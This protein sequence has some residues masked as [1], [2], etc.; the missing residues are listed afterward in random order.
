MTGNDTFQLTNQFLFGLHMPPHYSVLSYSLMDK[1]VRYLKKPNASTSKSFK[2]YAE[3]INH[4]QD[5]FIQWLSAKWEES[6]KYRRLE[7]NPNVDKYVNH[8]Y[9]FI[10]NYLKTYY[11]GTYISKVKIDFNKDEEKFDKL[12]MTLCEHLRNA[13]SKYTSA[14]I[15]NIDI[16]NFDSKISFKNGNYSTPNKVPFIKDE[17]CCDLS[18]KHS[19]E[20]N[21]CLSSLKSIMNLEKPNSLWLLPLNITK[22]DNQ[23]KLFIGGALS[24]GHFSH[25]D[26]LSFYLRKEI[27]KIF[28]KSKS[29]ISNTENV[30]DKCDYN[31]DKWLLA[32]S[33]GSL[34][35]T[36]NVLI[37]NKPHIQVVNN[38]TNERN[39]KILIPKVEY[40]PEFGFE[41]ISNEDLAEYWTDTYFRTPKSKATLVSVQYNMDLMMLKEK[42]ADTI[43][44]KL[45]EI[46]HTLLQR[47]VWT[48]EKLKQLDVGEYVLLHNPK[49]P[50]FIEIYQLSPYGGF[51]LLNMYLVLQ[52]AEVSN[53]LTWIQIDKEVICPIHE[54][55]K[56]AP[57]MFRPTPIPF[58]VDEINKQVSKFKMAIEN[59]E[60]IEK[61]RLAL[62]KRRKMEKNK[63]KKKL[64][65]ENDVFYQIK[66]QTLKTD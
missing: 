60:K 33:N 59:K 51:N 34:N 27:K 4:E 12:E 10:N 15:P 64:Q 41:K 58:K 31:Y 65:R 16:T 18:E 54:Y 40:Q 43:S 42:T 1:Y 11:N 28:R 22:N 19:T 24:T 50:F 39:E 55:F 57:C 25:H 36:Y 53:S 49:K 21:I 48:F 44:I 14:D 66:Q 62:K 61:E 2:S 6:L 9:N 46:K 5:L 7:I 23:K 20:I 45:D 30:I 32:A 56:V 3:L 26:K 29:N 47:L 13:D 63:A 38:V 37:R 35:H 17:V 52:Q 8:A